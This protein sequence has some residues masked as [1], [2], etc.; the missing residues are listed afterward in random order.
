VGTHQVVD[1]NSKIPGSPPAVRAAGRRQLLD[2]GGCLT[3]GGEGS[4][5][6]RCSQRG[7]RDDVDSGRRQRPRAENEAKVL[8]DVGGWRERG[9]YYGAPV[10]TSRGA[11]ARRSKRRSRGGGRWCEAA[12]R[13]G[14]VLWMRVAG[15]CR[16][17]PCNAHGCVG[18]GY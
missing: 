8:G 3:R 17:F 11:W 14:A 12:R 6:R 18:I 5:R 1:R 10:A 7:R 13:R 4:H 2:G 15:R 9:R 16:Q